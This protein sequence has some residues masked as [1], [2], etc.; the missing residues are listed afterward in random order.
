MPTLIENI[1]SL[2]AQASATVANAQAEAEAIARRAD[3]E[4]A[5]ARARLEAETKA[6]LSALEEET[7]ERCR[8]D[9]VAVEAQFQAARTAI[10]AISSNA[11]QDH[12]AKIA[13][14]FT[15]G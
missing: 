9:V 13:A 14:A 15:Q 3:D 12:A 10:D 6:K 4:I 11:I 1:L 2:E 5:A 8:R 7:N